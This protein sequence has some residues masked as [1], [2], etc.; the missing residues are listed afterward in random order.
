[1][2]SHSEKTDGRPKYRMI[3]DAIRSDIAGG[4]LSAGTKLPSE[5]DM[6]R[7]FGVAYATVR[8]AVGSLVQEGILERI[9][10]RG[11]FVLP[12]SPPRTET[13]TLALVVPSLSALWNIP[14]LYY[15]PPI[16]EGFSAEAVRCAFEPAV[17]GG[18]P[19]AERLAVGET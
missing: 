14:G 12:K 16:V 18:M 7:D 5:L 17:I 11:T 6:A 4:R 8:Q 3:K 10:G 9:H 19:E 1:M 15:L 13:R 2:T